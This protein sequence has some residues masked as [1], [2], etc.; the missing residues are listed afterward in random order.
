MV[1]GFPADAALALA[2]L[3]RKGS[4]TRLTFPSDALTHVV[5]GDAALA[6][7]RLVEAVTRL[8]PCQ[9]AVVTPAWLVDSCRY[10]C[11]LPPAPY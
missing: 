4:A 5:L 2:L 8:H 10:R 7:A 9:P 3:L 6:D 11:Q 1:L